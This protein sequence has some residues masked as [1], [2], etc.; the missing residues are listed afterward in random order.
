MLVV[1]RDYLTLKVVNEGDWLQNNIFQSTYAIQD[2][3]C[4]F[5]IDGGNCENI[6]FV[7]AV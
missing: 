2:K 6:T 7:K 5:V 4:H 3:V 1:R